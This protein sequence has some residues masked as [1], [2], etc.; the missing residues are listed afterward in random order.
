MRKL[1]PSDLGWEAA[2]IGMYASLP[3]RIIY[4][5]SALALPVGAVGALGVRG[6]F[7]GSFN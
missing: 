5:V 3:S 6:L 4:S 1:Q 7:V 2:F